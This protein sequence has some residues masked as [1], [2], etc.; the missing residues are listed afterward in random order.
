MIT[1]SVITS[2]LL[3]KTLI[4]INWINVCFTNESLFKRLVTRFN[5]GK[6]ITSVESYVRLTGKYL[7]TFV[8]WDTSTSYNEMIE[9]I[10][11]TQLYNEVLLLRS[12]WFHFLFCMVVC[13]VC[14]VLY[15]VCI[16]FVS[17]H[18]FFYYILNYS[19]SVF[20]FSFW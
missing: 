20:F 11:V 4:L 8:T 16:Y 9:F 17:F 19:D 5:G 6:Y 18:E 13:F 12:K 3:Y 2:T 14:F 7:V 10:A 1:L 15:F